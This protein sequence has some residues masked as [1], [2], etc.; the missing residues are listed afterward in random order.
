[1][2]YIEKHNETTKNMRSIY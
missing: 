2:I 1:M